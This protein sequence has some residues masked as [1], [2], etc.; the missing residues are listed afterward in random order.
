MPNYNQLMLIGNITK[1]PE[2]RY[3]TTGKAVCNS[4]IA[5]NERWTA[6]DGEKQERVCFLDFTV[7]GRGAET[8]CQYT[9]KGSGVMLA[10][11][12]TMEQWDDSGTTRT[13]H[14]LTVDTFQFLDRKPEEKESSNA[15]DSRTANRGGSPGSGHSTGSAKSAR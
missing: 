4:S 15:N 6:E 1:K 3:T 11:R 7:W 10:G 14:F 5:V 2:L 13:K 9:G 8:F 12:L